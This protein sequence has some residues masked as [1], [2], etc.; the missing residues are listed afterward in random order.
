MQKTLHKITTCLWFDSQ[1]EDA[2]KFYASV[3]A[4]AKVGS[5]SYYTEAGSEAHQK[6]ADSVMT[7]VCTIDGHELMGLNGGP[8]FSIT[9]AI[10]LY[11]SCKSETEVDNLYKKLSEGGSVLMELNKYPFSEK[12]AWVNDKFGVSWQ[13]ILTNKSD[14]KISPCLMFT[15]EHRGQAEE[16]INFYTSVFSDSSI[17]YLVKYEPGEPAPGTVKHAGFKLA[18][19]QFIA[20]DSPIDHAFNFTPGTSFIVKCKTQSEID[21]MWEKLQAGGGSPVECGWLTDKFGVSWQ[22]VP[23]IMDEMITTKDKAKKERYMAALMKM[24][25]LDIAEL[26]KAYNG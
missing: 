18:G 21:E 10:S 6:P 19:Q 1:A 7:T 5:T 4:N 13:L 8:V 20:M 16:A 14:Q 12:Y 22:V 2:I 15:G 11:V 23:T 25:K 17:D 24:K 9:P 26:E 3:F